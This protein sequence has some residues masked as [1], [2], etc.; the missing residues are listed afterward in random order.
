MIE[1]YNKESDTNGCRSSVSRTIDV[2][3]RGKHRFPENRPSTKRLIGDLPPCALKPEQWRLFQLL[4]ACFFGKFSDCSRSTILA[5]RG[6]ILAERPPEKRVRCQECLERSPRLRYV[7]TRYK[8]RFV[9]N[10]AE[11]FVLS[12]AKKERETGLEAAEGGTP[13]FFLVRFVPLPLL[14]DR[15]MKN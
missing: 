1:S 10:T 2:H 4:A 9:C 3:S 8:G 5:L 15:P 6:T 13:F 7:T 11:T 12:G 14:G